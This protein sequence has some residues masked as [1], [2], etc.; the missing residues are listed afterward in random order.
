MHLTSVQSKLSLAWCSTLASFL[1]LVFRVMLSI[2]SLFKLESACLWP[3]PHEIESFLL[4]FG[5][6]V[7]V[8]SQREVWTC[9][10]LWNQ[11]LSLDFGRIC[12]RPVFQNL[13]LPGIEL[14]WW[15]QT[16]S[17][18][19]LVNMLRFLLWVFDKEDLVLD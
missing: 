13:S 8:L 18:L 14:A 4:L 19:M 2:S 15:S 1:C 12:K 7:G 10:A 5:G 11:K 3:K 6:G 16:A 17:Q 9:F